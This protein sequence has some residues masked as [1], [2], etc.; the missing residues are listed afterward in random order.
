MQKQ[1]IREVSRDDNG[2]SSFVWRD[3]FEIIEIH[4]EFF[5]FL[6]GS[7][8]KSIFPQGLSLSCRQSVLWFSD[9]SSCSFVLTLN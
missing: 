4:L 5:P 1:K 7:N 9:L 3:K 8:N 2:S 6:S